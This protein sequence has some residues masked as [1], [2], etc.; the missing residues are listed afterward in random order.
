M[1]YCL[2]SLQLFTDPM[3]TENEPTFFFLRNYCFL[4]KPPPRRWYVWLFQANIV[5]DTSQN[6]CW[7]RVEQTETG[8]SSVA[9]INNSSGVKLLMW[10]IALT[11][12]LFYLLL[13]LKLSFTSNA[14]TDALFPR[15]CQPVLYCLCLWSL[16]FRAVHVGTYWKNALQ[17]GPKNFFCKN[18]HRLFIMQELSSVFYTSKTYAEANC[19]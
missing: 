17:T 3:F 9:K 2:W 12:T 10:K 18:L 1:L 14:S 5:Y 15:T 8:N 16:M 11:V 7:F 6:G 19:K 13:S 4:I